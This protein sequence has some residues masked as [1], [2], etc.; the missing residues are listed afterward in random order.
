MIEYHC[1]TL[2]GQQVDSSSARITLLDVVAQ[3]NSLGLVEHL[4][5]EALEV[6]VRRATATRPVVWL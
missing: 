6:V 3:R 4:V 2:G 1:G 5:D